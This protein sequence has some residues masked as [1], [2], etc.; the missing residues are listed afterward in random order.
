MMSI[1]QFKHRTTQGILFVTEHSLMA[2]KQYVQAEMLTIVKCFTTLN[3][4]CHFQVFAVP[5]SSAILTF[6]TGQNTKP[7]LKM[8]TE[9]QRKWLDF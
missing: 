7:K 9:S 6:V 2:I 8:C 1:K 3:G 5:G 4:L